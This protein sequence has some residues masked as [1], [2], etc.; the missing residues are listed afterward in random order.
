MERKRGGGTA[1]FL[2]THGW[3]NFLARM[4]W[5]GRHDDD[6]A[7]D[8]LGILLLVVEADLRHVKKRLFLHPLPPCKEEE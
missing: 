6:D 8:V 3:E 7:D 4:P 5:E 1:Q 2:P